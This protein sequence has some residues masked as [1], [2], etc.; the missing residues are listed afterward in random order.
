MYIQKAIEIGKFGKCIQK[1]SFN[2]EKLGMLHDKSVNVKR[3]NFFDLPNYVDSIL[4][5]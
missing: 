3:L 1:E 5:G 2:F 4:P